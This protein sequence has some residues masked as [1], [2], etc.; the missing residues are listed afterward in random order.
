MSIVMPLQITLLATFSHT[1]RNCLEG[2]WLYSYSCSYRPGSQRY[3][4]PTGTSKVP[5]PDYLI[6][7]FPLTGDKYAYDIYS[8]LLKERIIF[9]NGA[10][11]AQE[12]S[13]P[14]HRR[15]RS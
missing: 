2:I 8:R 5:L 13:Q 3:D 12:P 7:K 15:R 4:K 1:F 14:L 9:L 11:R 10:V 6:T